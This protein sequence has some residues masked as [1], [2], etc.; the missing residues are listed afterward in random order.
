MLAKIQSIRLPEDIPSIFQLHWFHRIVLIEALTQYLA[1]EEFSGKFS[2]QE[3]AN[4]MNPSLISTTILLNT[5]KLIVQARQTGTFA[6]IDAFSRRIIWTLACQIL[7]FHSKSEEM[8]LF[9]QK[10]LLINSQLPNLLNEEI[11][12]ALVLSLS[13]LLKEFSTV[14]LEDSRVSND[15]TVRVMERLVEMALE[16]VQLPSGMPIWPCLAACLLMGNYYKKEVS[17]DTVPNGRAKLAAAMIYSSQGAQMQD[18][19]LL[20]LDRLVSLKSPRITG[21]DAYLV[22]GLFLIFYAQKKNLSDSH[23]DALQKLHSRVS[24]SEP[25]EFRNLAAIMHC[26]IDMNAHEEALSAIRATSGPA[27]IKLD[28]IVGMCASIYFNGQSVFK[29]GAVKDKMG[30][31]LLGMDENIPLAP[32]IV[33]F[34]LFCS[35]NYEKDD[36][37]GL[38]DYRNDDLQRFGASSFFANVFSL[39]D[40]ERNENSFKLAMRILKNVKVLPRIDWKARPLPLEMLDSFAEIFAFLFAHLY[41]KPPNSSI[42]YSSLSLSTILK[43]TVV[44]GKAWQKTQ[45][46]KLLLN[47]NLAKMA[48]ILT[49]CYTPNDLGILISCLGLEAASDDVALLANFSSLL[50]QIPTEQ[51]SLIEVGQQ[52]LIFA[53]F[54][55]LPREFYFPQPITNDWIK[56]NRHAS[57]IFASNQQFDSLLD[58]F[59][60]IRAIFNLV[61]AAESPTNERLCKVLDSLKMHLHI[62]NEEQEWFSQVMATYLA[63]QLASTADHA[64]IKLLD[65]ALLHS[66]LVPTI[67]GMVAWLLVYSCDAW[68]SKIYGTT[69]IQYEMMCEA[70]RQYCQ[71]A[72]ESVVKVRKR[73]LRIIECCD[74]SQ[75]VSYKKLCEIFLVLLGI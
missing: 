71:I 44:R 37:R 9:D 68:V 47:E 32:W 8:G 26:S 51:L 66:Q 4:M 55:S 50:S 10:S 18:W 56:F 31:I 39:M 70:W 17:I 16:V 13:A 11:F 1:S 38:V 72:G 41:T 54:T 2:I 48:N 75:L 43:D 57:K 36:K 74:E 53:C 35:D 65:S 52:K 67:L 19:C 73:I 27:S 7:N 34:W 42:F 6:D 3:T 20:E 12:I 5:S 60:Y 14:Q 24:L 63:R 22:Q 33:H 21:N 28:W 45:I 23:R 69:E 62:I 15:L 49:S 59:D 40:A 46:T 30:E 25:A 58:N 64:A 29:T 61:G